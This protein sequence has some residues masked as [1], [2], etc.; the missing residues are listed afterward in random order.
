MD[1]RYAGQRAEQRLEEVTTGALALRPWKQVHMEVGRI[2]GE[3][4]G[5]RD[6]RV[7]DV[8]VEPQVGRQVAVVGWIEVAGSAG[9]HCASHSA[10][11][12]TVSSAP[13]M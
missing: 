6:R 7:M 4:L 12:A 1:P 8:A 11:N 9:H 2:L 5:R 10:L 13:T 3:H